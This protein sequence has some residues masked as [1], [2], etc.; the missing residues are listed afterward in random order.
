M[1]AKQRA[2][3]LKFYEPKYA[4]H[5]ATDFQKAELIDTKWLGLWPGGSAVY[6]NINTQGSDQV[7]L[8]YWSG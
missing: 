5:L 6:K 4:A 2:N 7:L 1:S 3:F 8:N